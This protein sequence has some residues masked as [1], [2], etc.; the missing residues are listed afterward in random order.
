[1]GNSISSQIYSAFFFS[2]FFESDYF[3]MLRFRRGAC[4]NVKCNIV[5]A[6]GRLIKLNEL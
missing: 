1:M 5:G 3:G 4:E 6:G 2:S